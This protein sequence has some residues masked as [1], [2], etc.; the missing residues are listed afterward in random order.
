MQTLQGTVRHLRHTTHTSGGVGGGEYGSYVSTSHIAILELEGAAGAVKYVSSEPP[1]ISEGDNVIVT[2]KV[3]GNGLFEAE[4]YKNITANV[5][6][7][8]ADGW[9]SRGVMG[10]MLML[11]GPLAFL[12]IQGIQGNELFAVILLTISSLGLGLLVYS[13]RAWFSVMRFIKRRD[14]NYS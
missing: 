9:V 4:A 5:T 1:V 11:A 8:N 3:A 2:G 12:L 6:G 14:L 7:S 13:F 10:F